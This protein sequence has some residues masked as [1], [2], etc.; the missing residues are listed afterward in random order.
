MAEVKERTGSADV[1][2]RQMDLAELKSI[3]EFAQRILNEERRVD[4]LI[5]NAGT[6]TKQ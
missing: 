4:I 1:V 6:I 3:K 5:N 2:F